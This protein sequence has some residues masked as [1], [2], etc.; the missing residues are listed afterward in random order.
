MMAT[1]TPSLPRTSFGAI[2]EPITVDQYHEMMRTGILLEGSPIELIDGVVVRK[3]KGDRGSNSM[4]GPRHASAVLQLDFHLRGVEAFGFHCRNQSA[5]SL[6][7]RQE[8]EPDLAIVRGQRKDFFQCHP[9]P[10]EIAVALEVSDSSLKYD[11]TTKQRIYAT[12]NIPIYWIVNLVDNQL[13]VY[14]QPLP[15]EDRYGDKAVFH[16]A[17]TVTLELATGQVLSL[18]VGEMF[19][20]A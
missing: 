18:A 15:E 9:R 12:A 1:A 14:T 20:A 16:P 6:A 8:P 3:D 11:Q 19:P 10:D 13:E 5:A 17:Q 2:I 7:V 4:A